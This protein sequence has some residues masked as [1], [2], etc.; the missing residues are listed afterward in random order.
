MAKNRCKK[1][2]KYGPTSMDITTPDAL[3]DVPQAMD[4][5]E[6]VVDDETHNDSIRKV[7]KRVQMKR[8][9]KVRK[10]K[11]IARAVAK[12]ERKAT[13]ILNKESKKLRTQSAKKLYD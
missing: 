13:K 6:T 4:T 5:S 9:Q 12:T 1:N 8:K 11:A 10:M 7:K 3:E 2:K